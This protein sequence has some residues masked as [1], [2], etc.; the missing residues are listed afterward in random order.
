MTAIAKVVHKYIF[1]PFFKYQDVSKWV[2]A[3]EQGLLLCWHLYSSARNR[4]PIALL[5]LKICTKAQLKN[6]CRNKR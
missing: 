4:S 3:N 1:K 2:T 6:V 5:M